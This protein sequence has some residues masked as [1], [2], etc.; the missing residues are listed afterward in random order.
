[1]REE[2]TLTSIRPDT[3]LL[4]NSEIALRRRI[5]PNFTFRAWTPPPS[6]TKIPGSVHACYIYTLRPINNILVKQGRVF[7]G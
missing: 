2:K 4:D 3:S 5:M 6:L 1:M 7:L